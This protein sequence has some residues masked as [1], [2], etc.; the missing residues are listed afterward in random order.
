MV[1]RDLLIAFHI[2]YLKHLRWVGKSF[3]QSF[4]VFT[5]FWPAGV[6]NVLRFEEVNLFAKQLVQLIQRF[7]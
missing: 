1:F 2:L 4:V 7:E 5:Q 3:G 6:T